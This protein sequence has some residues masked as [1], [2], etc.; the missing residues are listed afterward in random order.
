[1]KSEFYLNN[2][3]DLDVEIL[4]ES[5]S[6][7]RLMKLFVAEIDKDYT[8]RCLSA[9]IFAG[10]K[11]D[12][13]PHF[14]DLNYG[15]INRSVFTHY[16]QSGKNPEND[17]F[18]MNE[19]LLRFEPFYEYLEDLEDLELDQI[20]EEHEQYNATF[21]QFRRSKYLPKIELKINNLY[22]LKLGEIIKQLY[23]VRI[24]GNINHLP[25][26]YFSGNTES[27]RSTNISVYKIIKEIK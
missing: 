16:K 23:L 24:E 13:I 9:A 22:E 14:I 18:K 21:N 17:L 12:E 2:L 27:S 15:N 3:T 5:L 6:R 11:P 7:R 19:L 4:E 10:F 25:E 26:L 20:D 1:M 8:Q